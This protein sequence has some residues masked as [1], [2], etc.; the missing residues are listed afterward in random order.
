MKILSISGILPIPGI[1]STNDF[2]FQ[3]YNKYRQIFDDDTIVIIG[4]IKYNYNPFIVVKGITMLKKIKKNFM[5]KIDD[6]RV[7][8]FPFFSTWRYSNLHALITS[9]IFYLNR[10]KLKNLLITNKF[11]IIH[12]QY[13]FPDGLL[14]YHLSKKYNI[15][16]LITT[17]NE[18]HYF[19][20]KL[21]KRI[22]ISILKKASLIVPI[23]YSNY[24]YYKSLGLKDVLITPLGFNKN[25]QRIQKSVSYPRVSILTVAELI[26]LKN[27][28]KVLL[29]L[30][31][32]IPQY[33]ISYTIIGNGPEKK[34]LMEM[35]SKLRLSN[36]VTFI[37]HIPHGEIPDEMYKH[38]IFI[39]PSYF[40]TFGRVYFEAMAM[41][42]PIIC[43]KNS[44][45]YGIF[46]NKE[47]GI[48][49]DHNNID[50]I[51]GALEYLI[52]NPA[53]R[54][55]IGQNGK[56]LVENY[57]W[58]NVAKDMHSKYQNIVNSH[59]ENSGNATANK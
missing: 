20:H 39:M 23:N 50:E 48:A 59:N 37:N 41:G 24:I 8:I 44:G 58:E 31:Q 26:K 34:H 12:A 56:K 35:V 52:S 14:A 46:K 17:H 30:K 25:F 53:E 45:I 36:H 9:T 33:D 55:R 3:T 29:A 51:V 21:S 22:A 16:Y 1:K 19:E 54:R 32:L 18:R 57:T 27:I 40:E 13:I 38:D 28:D 6:F 49:V 2:V 7:E 43:A 11:D 5:G 15:P 47:E 10:K 4:P 42:I